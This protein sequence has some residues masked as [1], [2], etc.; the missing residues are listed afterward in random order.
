MLAGH[1]WAKDHAKRVGET[2]KIYTAVNKNP[3]ILFLP[4]Q[5][6][7]KNPNYQFLT[8]LIIENQAF[9]TPPNSFKKFYF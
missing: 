5:K 3:H 7:K 4:L 2:D 1:W 6:K 9:T 8:R